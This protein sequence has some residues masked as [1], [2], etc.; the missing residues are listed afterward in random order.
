MNDI[1][2]QLKDL[3][4]SWQANLKNSND[5]KLIQNKYLAKD[6]DLNT[7]L[8]KLGTL[9]PEERSKI[10]LVANKLKSQILESVKNLELNGSKSSQQKHFDVTIPALSP[11]YGTVH[12]ISGIIQEMVDIFGDLGFEVVEGE[13]IVTVQ[14]NF[15]QLNMNIDHPARDTQD[16]FYLDH[17]Y[18]LRTQ[19]SSM[20]VGEMARRVKNGQFPIRIVAPGK[21]YRRESDATHAAMFHQIEGV[22]VDNQTNFSDLKG[23]LKYFCER[24]F[25]E[26]VETRFRPH[27]F[28]YTEPSAELDIRLKNVKD[29]EK[30]KHTNWLEFGGCGMIHPDV[31]KRAGINP[32]VYQGW[33]FGMG[34]ERSLMI[35]EHIPDLRLLYANSVSFLDQF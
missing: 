15:E 21:T 11:S 32:K 30:G 35:R 34:V 27:F 12:P 2:L 8:K 24:L 33:A 17:N 23:S 14:N 7:I 10:G 20:Q 3:E 19:T 28:P 9:N 29:G 31:L 16:S 22:L 4:Q 1:L 13:E 18:L 26:E 25:G 6:S 5:P